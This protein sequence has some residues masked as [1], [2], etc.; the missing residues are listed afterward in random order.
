MTFRLGFEVLCAVAIAVMISC[1]DDNATAS[2]GLESMGIRHERPKRAQ[3]Q[4][5][6]TQSPSRFAF[7]AKQRP[8]GAAPH[9]DIGPSEEEEKTAKPASTGNVSRR[10]YEAELIELA[11]DPGTCISQTEAALAPPQVTVRFDAVVSAQGIISRI[12]ASSADL[13]ETSVECLRKRVAQ[14]RLKPPLEAAP[15][16]IHATWTLV[17]QPLDPK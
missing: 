11:A 12:E 8:P 10:D 17:R 1:K 3:E 16:R 13:N 7:R 9:F 6:R 14:G 5:R 15:R 2:R 4:P